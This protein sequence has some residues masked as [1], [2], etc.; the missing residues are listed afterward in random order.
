MY[1]FA[2]A[3][4][5]LAYVSERGFHVPTILAIGAGGGLG[6]VVAVKLSKRIFRD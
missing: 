5:V 1:A 6:C 3:A 4:V 2:E